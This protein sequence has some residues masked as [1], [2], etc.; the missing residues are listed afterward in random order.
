[1]ARVGASQVFF[2]VVAQ[3]NA[4]KLIADS[5]SAANVMQAVMVD[6]FEAVLK[7]I[8]DMFTG[9]DRIFDTIRD[10]TEATALAAVEF[11]KFYGDASQQ[12]LRAV[13]DE[14]IEIGEAYAIVGDEAILAGA[15]A[16]QVGQLI[17]RENISVLVEQANILANI[18]D[19]EAPAAMKAI[20]ALQ[21]QT[22]VLYGEIGR[23]G[24]E[25][26]TLT[27]QRELLETNTAAML[28]TLN[29]V[30]NHSVAVESDLVES[31]R[32][33][34]AQGA[35][36]GDT[37]GEMAAMSA[38][39]LEAGEE[40]GASGRAL[41]M[42]YARLGGDISGARTDMEAM[43]YTMTDANG[44][45]L[46]MSEILAELHASGFDNL[47]AAQKQNIAQTVAGNRHYVRFLKLMENYSRFSELVADTLDPAKI[48]YAAEQAERAMADLANQLRRAEAAGENLQAQFGRRLTPVMLGMQQATN[49]T[50]E[51]FLSLFGVFDDEKAHNALQFVGRFLGSFRQMEGVLKLGLGVR[52]LGVASEMFQSVQRSL[53]DILIANE[54]LHSKTA[55]YMKFGEK[56]TADQQTIQ[57]RIRYIHQEIARILE[58]QRMKKAEIRILTNM[59]LPL[60]EARNAYQ[61][62]ANAKME[63]ELELST[64]QQR[65]KAQYLTVL[66]RVNTEL[67]LEEDTNDRLL[68]AFNR[69][70]TKNQPDS[71]TSLMRRSQAG[72]D[73]ETFKRM[74][75][76]QKQAIRDAHATTQSQHQMFQRMKAVNQVYREFDLIAKANG[77]TMMGNVRMLKM[78]NH[79]LEVMEKGILDLNAR[80]PGFYGNNEK[81]RGTLEV[82]GKVMKH[83]GY[84][85]DVVVDRMTQL[86]MA[87]GL[88]EQHLSKLN[89]ELTRHTRFMGFTKAGHEGITATMQRLG[90]QFIH[91]DQTVKGLDMVE[92]FNELKN[93]VSMLE[94]DLDEANATMNMTTEQYMEEMLRVTNKNTGAFKDLSAAIKVL[95]ATEKDEMA[96]R[97]ELVE[98]SNLML[99]GDRAAVR[100]KADLYNEE[101]KTT[102][103]KSAALQQNVRKNMATIGYAASSSIG[104][105]TMSMMNNKYAALGSAM[106]YTTTL[107]PAI[108][109]VS[110]AAK[111]L[112]TDFAQLPPAMRKIEAAKFTKAALGIGAVV[113]ASVVLS[114]YNEHMKELAKTTQETQM[115]SDQLT[116]AFSANKKLFGENEGLAKA[117][118]V[119]NS[120]MKQLYENGDLLSQTYENIS[121]GIEGTS[122]ATR[123]YAEDALY[124]LD[125]IRSLR[126]E[127]Q[128]LGDEQQFAKLEEQLFGLMGGFGSAKTFRGQKFRSDLEKEFG[129]SGGVWF[130]EKRLLENIVASIEAGNKL[131]ESQ[132]DMISGVYRGPVAEAIFAMDDLILKG[133]SAE[134][135]INNITNNGAEGMGYLTE[136]IEDAKQAMFE[137]GNSKEELFFGGKYGNIT[138]D[139]YKQVVQKGVEQLYVTNEVIMTNNFNGFFNEQ[140]AAERIIG[141]LNTHLANQS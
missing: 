93:V 53:Q 18:S 103:L 127:G 105:L 97:T 138:G 2:N 100:A 87:M 88:E 130:S 62:A 114:I 136:A 40:Q 4:E 24:F 20:I 3:W 57:K 129:L 44:Q 41:R 37:F 137:F 21:Q 99:E 51:G 32:N 38:V 73:L 94:Q 78:S 72:M 89:E 61:D 104:L 80:F 56:A 22:G 54:N 1:M 132:R 67:L 52:S 46:S 65:M 106:M 42:M 95:Q 35:L 96:T 112:Y 128:A 8:D 14:L 15:R 135:A 76:A 82:L 140:E 117:L 55:T 113:A 66:K 11:E 109:Q 70:Y 36:V 122:G 19:Y 110:T 119:Q 101:L 47:N 45:L 16:A 75:V 9:I 7:P 60:E 115:A 23:V 27:Q 69:M 28:D 126:E 86:G 34:A 25:G 33:Y 48:N 49:N 79:E 29:T 111:N 108:T 131:T 90:G 134:A 39:L 6:S 31:M 123:K 77:N 64:Q 84:E 5:R 125:T 98:L 58:L 116:G 17:G 92:S 83:N 30:A 107:V 26:L 91:L 10:V 102:Q 139:L 121:Q 85:I 63:K 118:D 59:M 12:E 141:V 81:T 68:N 120:T 43:G 74:S 124:F 50:M 13:R 71:A 133:L